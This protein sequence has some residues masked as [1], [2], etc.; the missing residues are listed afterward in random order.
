[1]LNILLS[2]LHYIPIAIIITWL[3]LMAYLYIKDNK[4]QVIK[5]IRHIVKNDLKLVLFIFYT[6]LLLTGTIIARP[7]TYPYTNI[8]GYYIYDWLGHFNY[9]GLLNIVIFIPYIFIYIITFI[10]DK[11]FIKSIVL[12]ASTTVFI[13][14]YQLIFWVGQ[15]SMADILCNIFGGMLG[16]LLWYITNQMHKRIDK[17]VSITESNKR[18]EDK[19]QP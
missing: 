15:F 18:Y 10:P 19:D 14:L 17:K 8:L 1:M 2:Q 11:P 12:S 6:S 7:L 3:F 9:L 5:N 13:E 4:G 16:Y